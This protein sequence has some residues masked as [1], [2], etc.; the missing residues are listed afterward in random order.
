MSFIRIQLSFIFDNEVAWPND[1][2]FASELAAY[3]NSRGLEAE[4]VRNPLE[5]EK[6]G[7]LEIYVTK[8]KN[9]FSFLDNISAKLK[10]KG[11]K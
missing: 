8:K 3:L 9:S 1:D 11:V 7:T 10:E 5:D 4:I 2:A 6:P